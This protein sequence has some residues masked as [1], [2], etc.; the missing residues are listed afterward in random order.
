MSSYS[1][2]LFARSN[3]VTGLARLLD[4]YGVSDDYNASPTPELAD[5]RA[6]LADWRTVGNDLAEGIKVAA[7]ETEAVQPS[8]FGPEEINL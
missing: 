6:L 8:L 5:A 3:F 1:D 7:R 2:F 4:I